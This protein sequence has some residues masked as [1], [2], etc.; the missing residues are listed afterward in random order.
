VTLAEFLAPLRGGKQRDL[1]HATIY[2]AKHHDGEAALTV[3]AIRKR[4]QQARVTG[5]KTWNIAAVLTKSGDS[6]DS[7]GS[8]GPRLLWT[9]TDTGDKRI[10]E[11]LKLPEIDLDVQHDVASLQALA[12]KVKDPVVRD[13]I[14]EAIKCL[15]VGAL[16]AAIVFLWAAAVRTLQKRQ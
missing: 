10:R 8:D 14:D 6:V 13:Y 9:L 4:L 11:L 12:A 5:A 1:V 2:Y 16:R 15:G 7:V 3:E